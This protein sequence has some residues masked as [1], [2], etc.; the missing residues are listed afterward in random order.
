LCAFW[1][2]ACEGWPFENIFKLLA[3]T[4]QRREEV[5][6]MRWRELDIDAATWTFAPD[7]IKNDDKNWRTRRT[8]KN[9][10]A[11]AIDLHPEAVRLLDPTRRLGDF[12]F[13]TTGHSSVQGFTKAK[14]RLDKRMQAILGDRFQPWR[15]HDLRRTAASGMAALGFQRDVVGRVLNHISGVQDGIEGIYQRYE[16]RQERKQA[17]MAWGDHVLRLVSESASLDAGART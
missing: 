12:M 6:A 13:S 14:T 11:H 3:L 8:V 7:P 2:A 5:A 16:Y 1:Q 10:R 4:G 17:T 9:G 15:T